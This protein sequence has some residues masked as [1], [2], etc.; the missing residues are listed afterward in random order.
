MASGEKLIELNPY[1]VDQESLDFISTIENDVLKRWYYLG[2]V[3]KVE[4]STI[5]K[6]VADEGTTESFKEI[7]ML[8]LAAMF[9]D[10]EKEKA[11][12]VALENTKQGIQDLE[13][14]KNQLEE[15]SKRKMQYKEHEQEIVEKQ[16]ILEEKVQKLEKEKANLQ[17]ELEQAKQTSKQKSL[18][19][20]IYSEECK[21]SEASGF[22][23]FWD[24]FP[25]RKKE[26]E[27]RNFFVEYVS[28]TRYTAEQKN[29]FLD[30]LEAGITIKEI[31]K[32]AIEGMDVS[33]MKRLLAVQKK[34]GKGNAN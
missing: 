24:Q 25:K 14:M 27:K 3:E 12:N 16:V 17:Q 2:R 7:R 21:K 26:I 22:F 9:R 8:H 32:V 5:Q 19:T 15:I 11:M 1:S 13:I 20:N 29:F 6:H 31:Q 33:Y 34:G 30:C 18:S 23:S 4:L 10:E 28:S